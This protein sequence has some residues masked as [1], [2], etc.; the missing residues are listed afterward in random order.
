LIAATADQAVGTGWTNAALTL[1]GVTA[2]GTAIGTGQ[3]NT[4]A[5]VGQAGCTGGAAYIC[6]NLVAGG[7]GDWYLP[8]KD[9][10]N[11]LYLNRAAIGGFAASVYWTSTESGATGA[12]TQWFDTGFQDVQHKYNGP[13]TRAVRSF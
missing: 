11:Q 4:T 1:I 2:Q 12:R 13:N 10:L 6:D 3:A 8:S 9:E 7:Y 5:I